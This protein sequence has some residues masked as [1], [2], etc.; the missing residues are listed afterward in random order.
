MTG[1][2]P[3]ADR[4]TDLLRTLS[5]PIDLAPYLDEVLEAFIREFAAERG[6]L[7]LLEPS[8]RFRRV[9]GFDREGERIQRPEERLVQYAL[10]R[11]IEDR[12]PFH[13]AG[14]RGDRRFRTPAD[15]PGVAPRRSCLCVPIIVEERVEGALCLDSRVRPI[16]FDAPDERAAAR[17]AALAA[18]ALRIAAMAGAAA[19]GPVAAVESETP[20]DRP[21]D[22]HGILSRSPRM[23][24]VFRIIEA[25]APSRIPVLVTGESGAGKELVARA[26]HA[27]SGRGPFLSINCA[28]VPEGLQEAEL[29][30]HVRGAFTGADVDRAGLVELADGGTLLLDEVADMS[31]AMQGKLLRVLEES[32]VRRVGGSETIPVDVRII[33]SSNR[34]VEDLVLRGLFRA[35]LFWRLRGVTV[36][37]PPLRERSCDVAVLAEHFLRVFSLAS[38]REPPPIEREAG[39]RLVAHAWPGNVRELENEMR[40]IAAL[41]PSAVTEADL[42]PP[43]RGRRSGAGRSTGALSDIVGRSEKEAVEQALARAGGNKSRAARILGITR[44]SLYRRLEKHGLR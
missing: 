3:D 20:L 37:V 4:F 5:R 32:G 9:V 21:I 15:P 27:L 42:S 2:A 33:S 6:F 40:R 19:A 10:K 14:V 11:A 17:W 1:G 35:D 43:I 18:A 26:I 7:V 25:V 16:A 29:F 38:G 34:D 39:A 36:Q 41:A 24:E 31:P 44:K 22:F 12:R 23:K 8:G 30:G 28:A 13:A